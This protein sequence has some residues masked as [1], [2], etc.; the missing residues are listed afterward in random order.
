MGELDVLKYF[1]GYY[2]KYFLR[3]S[4]F[5]APAVNRRE[6]ILRLLSAYFQLAIFA[7]GGRKLVFMCKNEFSDRAI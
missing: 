6:T 5:G 4:S 3:L 1:I 2:D 7:T